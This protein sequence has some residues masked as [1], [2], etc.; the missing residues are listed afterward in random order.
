MLQ[1]SRASVIVEVITEP[2]RG[3]LGLGAKQ[4]VVRLT[5]AAR[6]QGE[7]K[8]SNPEPE[9][10]AVEDVEQDAPI[11]TKAKPKQPR[12][13][14]RRATQTA[15][16]E[17]MGGLFSKPQPLAEDAY[18]SEIHAGK[19]ALDE[20]LTLMGLDGQIGVER[21]LDEEGEATD[22]LQVQGD[23][24]SLLIGRHGETLAAL[25]YLTRLIASRD[26]QQ[27]ANFIIDVNEYK[28]GRANKLYHLAH[29]MADQAVE[30]GRMVKLEPMPPHERRIIHMALRKRDDV[31]T[32]S[33]DEGRYRKVT[34]IPK[35][36]R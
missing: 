2:S 13:T 25:Q 16:D 17:G 20:L 19:A 18:S 26:L 6:P 4:A 31:T 23:D 15:P 5:T 7:F 1:V 24:L 10:E 9:P 30:W 29:R 12:T 22:V 14:G 11:A 36:T 32:N 35:K 27:R 28:A 21:L 3:L 8:P 33:I 34:I